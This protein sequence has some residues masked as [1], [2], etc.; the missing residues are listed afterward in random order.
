MD[1]EEEEIYSQRGRGRGREKRY[2][3][4]WGSVPVPAEAFKEKAVVERRRW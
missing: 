3:E 4:R 2:S 1:E